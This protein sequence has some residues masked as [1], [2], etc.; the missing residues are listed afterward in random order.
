[1]ISLKA[2][3]ESDFETLISWVSNEKD[4]FQFAGTRLFSFP[5]SKSQLRNYIEMTDKRP[6]K[7]VLDNTNRV[8]GHCEINLENDIPRLSRILI[9]SEID[10]GKG[11]GKM[12]VLKMLDIIF[13]DKLITKVDLNVFDW[14]LG[15]ISC[16]QKIGFKKSD[17]E[18][19]TIKYN[20]ELWKSYNMIF[21]R[22][23]D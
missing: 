21:F 2:F 18:N 10:R 9:G 15:A 13:K 19:Q 7:V 23:N 11:Y 8:I 14:N 20:Q 17:I 1:M 6:Y 3:T 12:I 16:Y 4:L 5:L 22:R